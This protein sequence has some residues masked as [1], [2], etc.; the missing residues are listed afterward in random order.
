MIRRPPRST[1]TDT[2]FPYTT[3]FRSAV[4]R[5]I[6]EAVEFVRE[7]RAGAVVTNPINKQ[8]VYAAGFR[9][10]GHTEYLAELAGGGLR[11]VMMLACPGL[12][13]VPVT[14]HQSLA[15]AVR[16][17]TT[18]ETGSASC[19]ER[20]CQSGVSSVVAVSLKKKRYKG[21]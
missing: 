8:V 2:R 11:P 1:R 20:V 10:P 18:E 6:E 13:V 15:E 12:R 16:S 7:G 17:L 21:T 14:V 9:H 3:R 5:A 19:R 4:L